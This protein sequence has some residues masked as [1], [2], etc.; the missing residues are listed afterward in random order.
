MI[1]LTCIFTTS[2]VILFYKT[3]CD[4]IGVEDV[5]IFIRDIIL[6]EKISQ[7][8]YKRGGREYYWEYNYELGIVYLVAYQ[9]IFAQFDPKKLLVN[10][11]AYYE[12][13]K[14]DLIKKQGDLVVSHPPFEKDFDLLLA[15][16]REKQQKAASKLI[17]KPTPSDGRSMGSIPEKQKEQENGKAEKADH[18]SA[19][20]GKD[21]KLVKSVSFSDDVV[22]KEP[23]LINQQ[24]TQQE[25]NDKVVEIDTVQEMKLSAKERAR[26]RA[27]QGASG[28]KGKRRRRKVKTQFLQSFIISLLGALT[29]ELPKMI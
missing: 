20:N 29:I 22:N 25:E 16:I 13:N 19:S 23:E 10:M 1:D 14:V 21:S 8:S 9:N 5:A 11:K 6:Q 3:F 28:K 15:K 2:G 7:S 12:K 18:N 24:K 17:A 4:N 26:L 27:S